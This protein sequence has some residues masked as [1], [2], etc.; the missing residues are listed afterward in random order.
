M[1]VNIPSYSPNTACVFTPRNIFTYKYEQIYSV[2]LANINPPLYTNIQYIIFFRL[3]L[4]GHAHANTHATKTHTHAK[5]ET[6]TD[7]TCP[8]PLLTWI[9]LI[10]SRF[11]GVQRTALMSPYIS[12]ISLA[13]LWPLLPSG[14]T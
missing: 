4:T 3:Y 5:R 11:C 2:S 7:F 12:L 1:R 8:L 13:P 9:F 14:F 6:E 10:L